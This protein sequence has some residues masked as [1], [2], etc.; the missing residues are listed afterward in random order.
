M[1]PLFLHFARMA[2]CLGV[3]ALACHTIGPRIAP[4]L[5]K[6]NIDSLILAY[7]LQAAELR[8]QEN[9]VFTGDSSCLMD[10]AVTQLQKESGGSI[11]A[12]NL[13]TLSYLPLAF[14]A[15]VVNKHLTKGVAQPV[16]VLLITPEMV[17]RAPDPQ[18]LAAEL[19][20]LDLLQHK[21][22]CSRKE[23]NWA[24]TCALGLQILR[25]HLLNH[26]YPSLLPG[27]YGS[28]YVFNWNLWRLMELERG[29][30]ID[31]NQLSVR[32]R[33]VERWTINEN[34]RRQAEEFRKLLPNARLAFG[35]TPV[36]RELSGPNFRQDHEEM[37][38]NVGKWLKAD[39]L[40]QL[41]QTYSSGSF[42]TATHLNEHGRRKF[43]GEL[44]KAL[45]AAGIPG[46]AIGS[47]SG[48]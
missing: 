25:D 36:P 24:V 19:D 38:Q 20:L 9:V 30:L 2:C 32:S 21:K 31:P 16:I 1:R 33:R 35:L 42:A 45:E 26:I 41:P 28:R 48:Q 39:D 6:N 47:R 23:P 3:L 22:Y 40:L 13:G 46:K 43:S 7:K 5:P 15:E 37:L 29:G 17:T 27:S 14:F 12:I 44:L 10:V 8:G 4:Y 18:A 11:K 34:S